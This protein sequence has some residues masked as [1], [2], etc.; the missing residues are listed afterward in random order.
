MRFNIV[1]NLFFPICIP[2]I[3]NSFNNIH[4]FDWNWYYYANKQHI[5]NLAYNKDKVIA[6]YRTEGKKNKL[7]KNLFHALKYNTNTTILRDGMIEHTYERFFC[8]GVHRLGYKTIF[9]N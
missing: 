7:S 8:Y 4:T 3:Y 9:F 1:Q 2:N 6:H 5:G